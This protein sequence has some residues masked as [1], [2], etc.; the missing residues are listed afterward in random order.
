VE[1]TDK[2]NGNPRPFLVAGRVGYR[3]DPNNLLERALV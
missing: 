3:R 2:E 1:A